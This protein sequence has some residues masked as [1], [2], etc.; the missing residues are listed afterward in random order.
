MSLKA[1]VA[2]HVASETDPCCK[3]LRISVGSIFVP[4]VRP[5]VILFLNAKK[6]QLNM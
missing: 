2:E 4:I 5:I 1:S 3:I 6:Y